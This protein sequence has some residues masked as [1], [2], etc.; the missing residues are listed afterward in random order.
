LDDIISELSREEINRIDNILIFS[1][2]VHVAF[3]SMK[4]WL[5]VT[6]VIFILTLA[7]P[8]TRDNIFWRWGDAK[9][10]FQD[11]YDKKPVDLA[12]L[13]KYSDIPAPDSRFLLHASVAW[14][15]HPS[16]RAESI[17]RFWR[18]LGDGQGLATDGSTIVLPLALSMYLASIDI[19]SQIHST[20]EGFQCRRRAPPHQ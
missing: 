9:I 4:G 10:R 3:G 15:V 20:P 14:I 19:S 13:H 17:D 18:E 11:V 2:D 6:W 8:R 5:E 1:P 12:P 16:G 7:K